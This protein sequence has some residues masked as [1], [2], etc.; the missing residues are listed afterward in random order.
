[1]DEETMAL[2]FW[3]SAGVGGGREI[4]E[5]RIRLPQF[6]KEEGYGTGKTKGV[7]PLKKVTGVVEQWNTKKLSMFGFGGAS[8]Y[9]V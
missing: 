2:L 3:K 8:G 7:A 4:C 9:N 6:L 5:S 1:L